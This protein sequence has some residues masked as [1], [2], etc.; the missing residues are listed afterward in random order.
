L[1]EITVHSVRRDSNWIKLAYQNQK[2]QNTLVNIGSVAPTVTA[3]GAPGTPTATLSAT[4]AGSVTITWTAPTNTGNGT[5]TAYTVTGTPSGTCSTTGAL[6]CTITG[7]T[8]GTQY[9]FVVR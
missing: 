8:V 1:D 6:T 2:A 7:L 5:I 3:P 4:V 9:T